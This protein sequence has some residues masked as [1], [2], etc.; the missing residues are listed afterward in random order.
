MHK[1]YISFFVV[2]VALGSKAEDIFKMLVNAG[3]TPLTLTDDG[4]IEVDID[5]SYFAKRIESNIVIDGGKKLIFALP[6]IMRILMT[7]VKNKFSTMD[8]DTETFLQDYKKFIEQT[9]RSEFP[10]TISIKVKQSH[11]YFASFIK[12]KDGDILTALFATSVIARKDNAKAAYTSTRTEATGHSQL[13]MQWWNILDL[14]KV[15]S[16]LLGIQ[17][18]IFQTTV[19]IIADQ[20]FTGSG[21]IVAAKKAQNFFRIIHCNIHKY[22]SDGADYFNLISIYIRYAMTFLLGTRDFLN[23]ADFNSYSSVL[24]LW[25]INEKSQDDASG[26]RVVPVCPIMKKLLL[27]YNGLLVKKGL[28]NNIYLYAD[29]QYMP[30]RDEKARM[31]IFGMD[32]FSQADRDTLMEFID[33]A[34]LNSGRHLLTQKAIDDSVSANYID[35]YLGHYGAGEEPLGKFSTFDVA[36]YIDAINHTTTKIANEYG[37]KEL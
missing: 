37:I 34:P 13:V 28:D 29:A 27:T 33:F 15:A 3:D 25:S 23:S 31:I 24:G 5:S 21:K 7:D 2:C 6:H 30:F 14:D 11:R 20:K 32:N 35:A 10:K 36:D 1:L 4:C 22:S 12:N 17:P 8:I 19:S 26:I 18:N 16:S 9:A